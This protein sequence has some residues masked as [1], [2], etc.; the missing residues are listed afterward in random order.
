[1][2]RVCK[3]FD[4]VSFENYICSSKEQ[5]RLVAALQDGI[6]NGFKQ[7]I[8]ITGG[9]GTG[10]THLAYAVL[11]A[12]CTRWK[13]SSGAEYYSSTQAVYAPIK[14]IID[15]IKASWRTNER[16]DLSI[17]TGAPLLIIDEV[18]VQ[19]GSDSERT[20]LFEVF[21]KRYNDELPTIA[22]SNNNT[23]ALKS[24]LGQRIYDRLTGGA[25]I[26]ELDGSS[27]RQG[28]KDEKHQRN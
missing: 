18:G 23:E 26:F 24:I 5:E 15:E 9:V 25:L 28:E 14:S 12:L 19:Y 7:N 8:V 27:Y 11:N 2:T 6:K 20:E 10:K 3:R 4:K 22:I 1:M 21:D 16:V 13:A 17:Y